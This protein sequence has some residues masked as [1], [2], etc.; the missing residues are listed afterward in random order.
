[1]L[2]SSRALGTGAASRYRKEDQLASAAIVSPKKSATGTESRNPL[3]M[4][5][6]AKAKLTPEEVAAWISDGL[7][8][9]PD[10]V[11]PTASAAQTITGRA[12]ITPNTTKVRRRDS[13]RRAST[14]N[15]RVRDGR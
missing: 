11:P 7:P 12:T 14:R 10:G 3:A 5:S 15:G 6:T 2:N 8:S 13:C 9:R 1:L 4:K